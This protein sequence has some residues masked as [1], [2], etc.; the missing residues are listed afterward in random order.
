PPRQGARRDGRQGRRGGGPVVPLRV[1]GRGDRDRPGGDGAVGA[2]GERDGV[3]VAA[4]PVVDHPGRDQRLARP[5]VLVGVRLGEGRGVAR[6][7]RPG[8]DGRQGGGGGRAVVPLGVGGG[9]DGDGPGGDDPS[10]VVRERD[11][12]V[13]P[14]VPV[15]DHPG[16]DQGLARPGILVGE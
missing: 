3:V 5:G 7:Q 2:V 4:V 11:G 15:V 9:G 13:G 10:G 16:R 1:R 8:R 6:G 12:V 14:A